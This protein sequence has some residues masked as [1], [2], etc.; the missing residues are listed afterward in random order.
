MVVVKPWMG[1]SENYYQILLDVYERIMDDIQIRNFRVTLGRPES[2]EFS[3]LEKILMSITSIKSFLDNIGKLGEEAFLHIR[4]LLDLMKMDFQEL[5]IVYSEDAFKN[6]VEKADEIDPKKFF[7]ELMQMEITYEGTAMNLWEL[8]KYTIIIGLQEMYIKYLG[9]EVII[10][11]VMGNKGKI[12]AMKSKFK[13]WG[14][15][16]IEEPAGEVEIHVPL[17]F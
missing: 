9:K 4:Y 5:G 15:I 11:D 7:K 6:L 14:I 8:F 10:K 17:F 1:Y 16:S 3:K 12:S 13:R 2:K